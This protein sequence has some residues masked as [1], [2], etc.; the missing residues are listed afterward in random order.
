MYVISRVNN[1]RL[2]ICII[3]FTLPIDVVQSMDEDMGLNNKQEGL[4]RML[5]LAII[6]G[7]HISS[8]AVAKGKSSNEPLTDPSSL[9]HQNQYGNQHEDQH[10]SQHEN[11][12]EDQHESQQQDK[13]EGHG[14]QHKNEQKIQDE[15]QHESQ[16]ENQNQH[17]DQNRSQH[18]NQHNENQHI[19]EHE[20]EGTKNTTDVCTEEHGQTEN[21][22]TPQK[23]LTLQ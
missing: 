23:H 16:Y 4:S 12:H 5:S 2:V 22:H 8:I 19:K 21:I 3:V 17:T 15:N 14:N 18:E 1:K 7:R 10:E 13:Y 6:P 11:Q 9:K 20:S